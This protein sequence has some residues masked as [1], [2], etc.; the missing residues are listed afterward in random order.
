MC[1][2]SGPSPS[3]M[4]SIA[5]ATAR[6]LAPFSSADRRRQKSAFAE[7]S[8][9]AAERSGHDEEV[10]RPR[11]GSPRHALGAPERGDGDDDRVRSRRVAAAHRDAG[12]R[13]ALVER[14]RAVEVRCG[15]RDDERERL[16]AR[17]REVADVHR[18]SA[19]AELAP[20]EEV[21]AEVDAFDERVL[22]HDEA[23]DLRR[24]VL[25]ADDQAAALELG[26]ELELVHDSENLA[27][28][29]TVSGVERGQ[30]V[31][32]PRVERSRPF[33]A[34]GGVLGG[35]LVGDERLRRGVERIVG[36][37]GDEAAGERGRDA[38]GSRHRR[39]ER[40]TVRDGDDPLAVRD[41]VD[42]PGDRRDEPELPRGPAR[43]RR[44]LE[45][46]RH[47]LDAAHLRLR[48]DERRD[49]AL[50]AAEDGDVD[51]VEN[52]PRGVRPVRRSRRRRQGRARPGSRARSRRLPASS[53]ASIQ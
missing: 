8:A 36:L 31:V 20:V 22:R 38:A 13:D 27:R 25:D 26:E 47:R 33:G 42:R 50:V 11:A 39:E 43:E 16:G 2:A 53:M 45:P 24:V 1:A 46:G 14:D 17:S 41:V 49:L 32:E 15:E 21:E 44:R 7:R 5:W 23:V 3:E 19:E 40:M 4:S 28:P 52:A 48:P 37:H 12:L 10:A 51:L 18:R 35:D 34:G 9:G 29:S 6:E 30:R